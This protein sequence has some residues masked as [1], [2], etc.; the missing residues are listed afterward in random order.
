MLT[1]Q[2]SL[3]GDRLERLNALDAVMKDL[4]RA[5]NRANQEGWIKA[6]ELEEELGPQEIS[7]NIDTKQSEA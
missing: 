3:D 7:R 2:P 4:K 5:D 6:E 1:N